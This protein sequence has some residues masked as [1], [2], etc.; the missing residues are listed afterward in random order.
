MRIIFMTCIIA[1]PEFNLGAA[2]GKKM[3]TVSY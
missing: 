1:N 2:N 3:E